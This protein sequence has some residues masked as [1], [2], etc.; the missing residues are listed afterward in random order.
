MDPAVVDAVRS[1]MD[2]TAAFLTNAA[3]GIAAFVQGFLELARGRRVLPAADRGVGRRD[4]GALQE[5]GGV[6]HRG[7]LIYQAFIEDAGV[8]FR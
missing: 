1:I 4:R 7:R 8:A 6:R 5:L 3:P 2:D